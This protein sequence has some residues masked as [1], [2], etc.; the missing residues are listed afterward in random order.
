MLGAAAVAVSLWLWSCFCR[1]PIHGWNAIRLAPSFMWQAGANPYP[2]PSA[3]PVTTWIYGPLPIILQWPATLMHDAAAALL[4]AGMINLFVAVVPLAVAIKAQAAPGTSIANR[5]W[6]LLLALACWPAVNLIFCQAGNTAIACGLLAGAIV[7]GA[8]PRDSAQLWGAAAAATLALW[9]RQTELGPVLGQIAYL[10]YRYGGRAAAAQTLRAAATGGLFGLAFC[11]LFGSEGLI[12]NMFV[13]PASLPLVGFAGKVRYLSYAGD[14]AAYL[15]AYL[16]VPALLVALRARRFFRREHPA[17]APV[18]VFTCSIPFDL[19]GF[20]SVGGNIN[21]FHSAVYLLPVT[22]LWLAGRKPGAKT[23]P[24]L[25]PV[26]LVTALTL[27]FAALWPLPLRPQLTGL[28][29]G[30]ALA[31]QLPRQVYFPWNPLLTYF[32]DG[33]F[34]HVEDG[35]ITRSLA[36]RPVPSAVVKTHLPSAMCVVAYHRY[37]IESFV[38]SLIPTNA[39][40]DTFGE[41]ILLSWPAPAA[42]R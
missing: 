27:Q 1:F 24:W 7:A 20:F 34:Y 37:A 31:R 15:I 22:T 5:A 25:A 4:A 21:S 28:R 30:A 17:L 40:R 10:G 12:Y 19:A 2:G 39:K 38:R 42:A 11:G 32:S 8:G 35:L 6:A 18:L 13:I 14:I 9:A 36:G 33:R 16:I 41:W 3:G 26:G 23:W 29:Q